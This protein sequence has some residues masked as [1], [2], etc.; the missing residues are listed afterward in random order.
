MLAQ[1]PQGPRAKLGAHHRPWGCIAESPSASEFLIAC[2]CLEALC[3]GLHCCG[4]CA[5]Q[6][7]QQ[8]HLPKRSH[9]AVDTYTQQC[10]NSAHGTCRT[11]EQCSRWRARCVNMRPGL[12]VDTPL[13]THSPVTLTAI[14]TIMQLLRQWVTREPTSSCCRGTRSSGSGGQQVIPARVPYLPAARFRP[15]SID[16]S[17][18]L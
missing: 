13:R 9:V 18:N 5:F 8:Q 7:E 11:P 1:D 14:N 4:Q 6:R 2:Y 16:L 15:A 12:Q 17:Y 10:G 3:S